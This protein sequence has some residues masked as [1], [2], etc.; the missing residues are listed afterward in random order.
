MALPRGLNI[1]V[2]SNN[3]YLQM[4]ND[5]D[6]E[7]N[8]E[9]DKRTRY[10]ESTT[11]AKFELHVTLDSSFEWGP[12]DAVRVVVEYDGA[13]PACSHDLRK[14]SLPENIHLPIRA[15]FTSVHR[16][17]Q[18]TKQWKLGLLSFGALQTSRAQ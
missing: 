12:S 3:Q 5:P 4:Y 8:E 11:G 13:T 9:P 2:F 1:A 17:C 10:I 6:A 16:F 15:K 14:T 7:E 18:M